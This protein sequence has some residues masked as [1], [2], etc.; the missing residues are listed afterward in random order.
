[1]EIKK[2]EV[3]LIIVL[4]T[5]LLIAINIYIGITAYN[6]GQISNN[7]EIKLLKDSLLQDS[8]IIVNLKHDINKLNITHATDS[9]RNY[10]LII[11]NYDLKDQLDCLNSGRWN[12][13]VKY[14]MD[15][16]ATYEMKIDGYIDDMIYWR[17]KYY[18]LLK[19][20]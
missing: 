6:A 15:V 1:M 19:S 13:M 7:D 8:C 10:H 17:T 16:I 14:S 20:K 2:N 11:D 4:S 5:L 18:N 3:K 9:T 12:E